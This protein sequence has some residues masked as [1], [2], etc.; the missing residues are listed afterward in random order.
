MRLNTCPHERPQK[1]FQGGQSRHFAYLSQVVGD[2]TQTDVYKK[3]NVQCYGNSC[4]QCFPYK[5]SY[6][7]Q[8]FVSVSMDFFRLR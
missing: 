2:A 8:M 7:E 6:S 5:K 3:E 4:I 1:F